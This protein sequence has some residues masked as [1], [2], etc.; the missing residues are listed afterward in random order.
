WAKITEK[1][2]GRTDNAVKNHWYSSMSPVRQLKSSRC[3][4]QHSSTPSEAS[5]EAMSDQSTLE[6]AAVSQVECQTCVLP[7]SKPQSPESA[8]SPHCAEELVAEPV[9]GWDVTC[10]DTLND[11]SSTTDPMDPSEL[12]ELVDE[13]FESVRTADGQISLTEA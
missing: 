2:P 1:L 6:I 12:D 10:Y 9:M 13:I 3:C 5:G 8:S 7:L 4:R 11:T